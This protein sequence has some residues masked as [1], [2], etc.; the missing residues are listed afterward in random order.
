MPIIR[1][2]LKKD[3]QRTNPQ[4]GQGDVEAF[5]ENDLD[6]ILIGEFYDKQVDWVRRVVLEVANKEERSVTFELDNYLPRR[7]WQRL[8]HNGLLLACGNALTGPSDLN[9]ISTVTFAWIQA[10]DGRQLLSINLDDECWGEAA[11]RDFFDDWY[12]AALT[13]LMEELEIPP[14]LIRSTLRRVMPEW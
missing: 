12:A 10:D 3:D 6:A 8:L 7:L 1:R 4:T 11:G 9:D 14:A 2:G 13:W 5:S